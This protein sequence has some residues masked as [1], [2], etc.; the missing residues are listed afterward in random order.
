MVD[1]A[2]LPQRQGIKTRQIFYP[3][4]PSLGTDPAAPVG[5][6]MPLADEAGFGTAQGLTN[7]P[8]FKGLRKPDAVVLGMITA[9]GENPYLL[10]SRIFP[11]VLKTFLGDDGYVRPAGGTTKLHRLF[12]PTDPDAEMGSCQ[13]QDESR[14][15]PVQYI[16][17]KGVRPG[18]IGLTYA[19][20]G[21]A[22]YTVGFT[23]IGNEVFTDLGGTVVDYPSRPFS[24]F[25]GYA[26]LN[27]YYLVGMTDFNM[28]LDAGLAR[29]DAA[30]H[31]GQAAAIG[32][33]AV[34]LT[35]SLGLMF[36]TNGSAPENN[37]NFY[38]MAVNQQDVPL[39]VLWADAPLDRADHWIRILTPAVRFSRR[40]FRPGGA[41]GKVIT[42]DWRM[43][44][45]E[46]ADIAAEKFN[47]IR[48]PYTMDNT[49][50][51]IGIRVDGAAA[52]AVTLPTGAAVT[53]DQIVA[54]INANGTLSAAIVA[55]S[56]VGRVMLRHKTAGASHSIG[57]DTTTANSAHTVLGFDAVAM[58]GFD[59]TPLIIEVYNDI[60][61]DL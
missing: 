43:V 4:E 10:E 61:T 38:N 28:S 8:V 56:F 59:D 49:N 41:V 37:M 53:V 48:G 7:V 45:T 44:D 3:N 29:Q 12:I 35:G 11:R 6:L 33:G 9:D 57:I 23:G 27:G 50:N 30:F 22:R 34:N 19:A 17:N 26:K 16:R 51:V 1:F 15:T 55:E 5:Y 20:E 2:P 24:Y 25:N 52:T 39:D 31:A 13:I 40:G 21:G 32:Y 18:T 58:S 46:N 60:T 42:Q 14:E 54:A 47:D 36:S